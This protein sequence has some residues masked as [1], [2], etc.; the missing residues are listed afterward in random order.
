[1][2][3]TLSHTTIYQY[4]PEPAGAGLRLKLFPIASAAQRLDDW[5]LTVNGTEVSPIFT[6]ASGDQIALWHHHSAVEKVEITASGTARTSD[7]AGVLKDVR[8]SMPPGVYLRQTELTEPDEV[9][10][11]MTAEVGEG[12]ALARLHKL[13]ESVN[14]AIDYRPGVTSTE[15]TAAEAAALGAGICQDQAHVFIAASRLLGIPARYVVGYVF[16]PDADEA[17]DTHAWAEAYVPGLGWTGFDITHQ[18]CPTDAYV[19]LCCGLDAED[20]APIR[21]NL[22]GE[23]DETLTTAVRVAQ[24]TGQSQQ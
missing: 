2:E 13:S 11:K 15:T 1:M 8:S 4:E 23:V 20:A 19:R 16:D 7:T 24:A 21:G 3:L 10:R 12:D 17:Q 9:I 14:G 5:S 18:L 22:H 6:E